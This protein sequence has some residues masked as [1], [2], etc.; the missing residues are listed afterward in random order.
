ML[1]TKLISLHTEK[2][3]ANSYESIDGNKENTSKMKVK[4]CH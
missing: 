2:K 4:F 1:L 3:K